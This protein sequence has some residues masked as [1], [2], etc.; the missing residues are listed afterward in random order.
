[1]ATQ[2]PIKKPLFISRNI[3]LL[4]KYDDK[5]KLNSRISHRWNFKNVMHELYTEFT[6]KI[7]FE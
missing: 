2:K 7:R 1:M 4:M 5:L 3:I 6:Q